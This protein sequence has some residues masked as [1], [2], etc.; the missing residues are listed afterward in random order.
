MCIFSV[1]CYPHRF[2]NSQ[3]LYVWVTHRFC[4]YDHA[5]SRFLEIT[6]LILWTCVNSALTAHSELT[7]DRCAMDGQR[8]SVN[9]FQT[10]LS[11]PRIRQRRHTIMNDIKSCRPK[12]LWSIPSNTSSG[13]AATSEYKYCRAGDVLWSSWAGPAMAKWSDGVIFPER[14]CDAQKWFT[15][16]CGCAARANVR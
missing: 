16:P 5:A 7:I 4:V 1:V 3:T 12:T 9:R 6:S 13:S 15:I 11:Y 14:C 2:F 10:L 8:S